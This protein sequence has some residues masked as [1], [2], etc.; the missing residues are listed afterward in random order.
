MGIRNCEGKITENRLWIIRLLWIGLCICCLSLQGFTINILLLTVLSLACIVCIG[1]LV[2]IILLM[3]ILKFLRQLTKIYILRYEC[4]KRIKLP[5]QCK[6]PVIIRLW[7]WHLLW[8]SWSSSRFS[9]TTPSAPF[10]F[11]VQ[12]GPLCLGEWLVLGIGLYG[13]GYFLLFKDGIHYLLQWK[14]NAFIFD[15]LTYFYA[16]AWVIN[17]IDEVIK[18]CKTIT[19]I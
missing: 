4:S 11:L 19:F 14:Y 12:M 17:R 8:G 7:S 15:S 10:V 5:I 1:V 2:H 13:K 6:C 3:Y 9:S 18:K 16:P